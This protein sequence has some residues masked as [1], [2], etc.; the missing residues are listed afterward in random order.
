MIEYLRR[1]LD[2]RQVH[3]R[4]IDP[5]MYSVRL[6][7][8][9]AYLLRKDWKEVA[10]DRPGAFVF[11][12]PVTGE[13]GPFYQWIP[14]SEEQRG[15]SQAIYELLAALADI[16]DRYAGDVLTDIL[17]HAEDGALSANGPG[18]SPTADRVQR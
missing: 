13:D 9:R 3:R 1:H 6:A 8:I 11:Q 14:D 10:P 17:E 5:R 2:D 18:R 7:D 12:E 15:Y 4:W 16:E